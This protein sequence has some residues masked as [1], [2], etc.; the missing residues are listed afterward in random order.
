MTKRGSMIP[1]AK[2]FVDDREVGAVQAVI[3]SG[4][5]MQGPKVAE[6]ERIFADYCGTAEAVAVTSCTA[7]LHLALL[8][9]GVGPGDEVICP[10]LSFIATANAIRHTGATPVFADVDPRTHNLDPEAAEK[11]ITPRTKVIMVVHQLGLPAD[12]DRFL[13]LGRRYGVQ[14]L[15]DAACALGSR[16]KGKP[17]GGHSGTACFSFH[18]RKVITTGEGGMVTTNDRDRA[19]RLRILRQHGMDASVAERDRA[20]R[21]R[22]EKYLC[23]GYNYRMTDIQAAIGIEQMK[24]LDEMLKRRRELAAGY[25]RALERHPWLRPL[26]VPDY[27]EPNF[28]SYAVQLSEK[29][30]F[31]RNE[32]MQKLLDAG[33]ASRRGV[34]LAHSEPAYAEHTLANPLPSSEKASANSLLLPLYPQMSFAELEE[35]IQ[36]ISRLSYSPAA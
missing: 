33:I 24:K 13:A 6:F 14:I 36:A 9:T 25:A 27:V 34:M 3:R 22:I 28:Q 21:V 12:I 30:P 35:V 20:G 7:A 32:F 17:I 31:G 5:I 19:A 8:T 15:E 23:L 26:H 11:A 10:S 1:F 18:P 16:Y 4:W 2:P 29:A